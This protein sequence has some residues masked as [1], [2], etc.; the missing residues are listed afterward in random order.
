MRA[1]TL[2]ASLAVA[3]LLGSAPPAAAQAT[4]WKAV[5]IPPLR[6]FTPQQPLRVRLPN[7]MV[8]FLQEDHALPLVSGFARIR[9]G[10]RDEPADKV[11]LVSIY[12]QVW[13][14]GGTE[15]R[16]GDQLDDFLEA[17][18]AKVET[19]GGL[20]STSIS[21]DCLKD[22]LDEVWGIFDELLRHP[23]FRED[24]LP[25]AKNMLDTGIARRNDDPMGIASREARAL[26]YGKD[27]P[28]AREP[29]YATVA[30]VTRADLVAWH[31]AHV[32]P[33]DI[34]LGIVGDFDSRAM[35]ARLRKA[36]GAWPKGPAPH[37][38][39]ASFPG[40]KPGVYFVQ[41]DD[42]NQS[43]IRMVGLGTRRDNPDYY[44]IE[45]M[46]EV[47]G[48]GFSSRLVSN[49]RS[50]KG[51]AYAVGG[52]VGMS[53]DHPGLFMLS[54]GTKSGSTAAAIDALYEEIDNLKKN[55]ATPKELKQAK[56]SI[57]NSFIFRFDSKEKV[58][59]ERMLY[60]FYG[61]PADF[62][63]R[64]RA[65]IERVTAADVARAAERYV[66]KGE[67]AL[68]VVG[69]AQ[70]FDRPLSS[71]G[72]VTS[73]DISIPEGAPEPAAQGTPRDDAAARALLGKV[74]DALGG[75]ERARAIKT[76]RQKSAHQVKTP[77]GEMKIEADTLIALPD[78]LRNELRTPMGSM[79]Q[80]ITADAGFL[81]GP[82]G[83][84]ELPASQRESA[85]KELRTS[86]LVVAQH[87]DDPKLTVRSAGTEKVG[88]TE[89]ALLDL[90]YDGA[91]VRWCVDPKSG[92]I[93]RSASRV[94]S[95]QGP[96]EQVVELSDWRAVDGFQFAFARALRRD[97]EDGGSVAVQEIQV[98]PPVDPKDF[99]PKA[100]P[101]Q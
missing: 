76:L 56:D 101:H 49:I 31:S 94:A 36:F 22:S 99:E 1:R 8:I 2:A 77:Q 52:G 10:S 35:Q 15:T 46:N 39:K 51:L 4:D 64:Y 24:K 71:F 45:V 84:H 26:G 18:G 67:L 44:A 50:K 43:N 3:A 68:L 73:L 100:Q 25:I 98:N 42:V 92:R 83:R 70:D 63:D 6:A 48:G 65:G 21:F 12:G 58:M 91:E 5:P 27:S 34:I 41:K 33:N 89:A 59:L 28:Y 11:G 85:L 69:R 60:E 88:E 20:D 23:A 55:P 87:I 14:T 93:L 66:H 96:V 78:R 16:T 40:P 80:V 90:S 74:V 61:Y 54:M 86:P 13:R 7:G 38:L 37:A 75:V 29:E 17:R 81:D 82:M 95:P 30:A 19:S 72:P 97:G 57:L 79:S 32:H 62:L 9:G 47:F 53:F